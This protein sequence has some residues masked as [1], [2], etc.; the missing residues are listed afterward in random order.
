[1]RLSR[2][3]RSCAAQLR[4]GFSLP[5][6]GPG[7]CAFRP[8]LPYP[9]I[10]FHR[11]MKKISVAIVLA[12]VAGCGWWYWQHREDDGKVSYLSEAVERGT[13]TK[14]VVATGVIDAVD[15]VSVG[16][17]VSGQIKKLH[18]KLG[19][20]VKKGDMVAEIDSVS[21][22]NQY[23]SDKANLASRQAELVSKQAALRIAQVRYDREKALFGKNATSREALENAENS[24]ALARAE[25]V[26]VQSLIKQG[27]L[28][29]D[30]DELNLGYT[31]IVAP[32]DG[33]VVSV[34]VDEGQTVNSNQSAPT[35]VQIADLGRMENKIEISEGDIGVIREK[36]PLTF[37]VLS[38]PDKIFETRI[39]SLDP[40]MTTLSNGGYSKT[41]SADSGSSSSSASEAVY[42]Y[43][44]A[45]LDNQEGLLRIGMTTENTITVARAEDVLLVPIIAVQNRDGQRSV[46]V[47]GAQGQPEARAVEI[48]LSDGVRV[49]IKSGLKEGERV[50]MGQLSQ[51]EIRN[52][53][54]MP[55][56]P[57]GPN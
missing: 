30:T 9:F 41:S 24:L 49:E 54:K 55:G 50:I 44:K 23:N 45:V 10:P 51:E 3:L 33:T 2:T 46:Q 37:T 25:V 36:M 7:S 28:A 13:I 35:I 48:G 42:F 20:Q 15:L 38:L 26:A 57:G 34:V 32:L 40:G 5:F 8:L 21:Q 1:M 18:V 6:C 29:I 39:S 43:G 53:A 14:Q 31:R 4:Y 11:F 17:Q 22:L 19:Q 12:L 47:L 56:G 52:A 16:A 27:Q